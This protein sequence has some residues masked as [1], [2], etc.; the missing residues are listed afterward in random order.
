MISIQLD[1]PTRVFF[2]GQTVTGRLRFAVATKT[3]YNMLESNNLFYECLEDHLLL[4]P[5]KPHKVTF[6]CRAGIS[7]VCTGLTS[8]TLVK[9]F[10]SASE[11]LFKILIS[12]PT[13]PK[14]KVSISYNFLKYIFS[15]LTSNFTIS[16]FSMEGPKNQP[17]VQHPI[18]L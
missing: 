9:S 13:A 2:G 1:S 18:F 5:I 16:P 11:D 17:S 6:F 12:L 7:L 10:C 15:S 8:V 14:G 4:T 3:E